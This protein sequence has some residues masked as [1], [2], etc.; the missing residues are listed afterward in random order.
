MSYGAD[1]RAHTDP[2][3]LLQTLYLAVVMVFIA[4]RRYTQTD[5][6]SWHLEN[7]LLHVLSFTARL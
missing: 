1:Y 3:S 4:P 6:L 5:R 2:S 7:E